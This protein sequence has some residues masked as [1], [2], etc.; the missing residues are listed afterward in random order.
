M[1]RFV[2]DNDHFQFDLLDELIFENVRLDKQ[3]ENLLNNTSASI[4]EA[5]KVQQQLFN[6]QILQLNQQ[7]NTLN[8]SVF[9]MDLSGKASVH[10]Y[11]QYELGTTQMTTVFEL[12]TENLEVLSF[13]DIL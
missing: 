4:S 7:L 2:A 6:D 9:H 8:L 5:Y 12:S 10:Y 1:H 13:K 11:H 3:M